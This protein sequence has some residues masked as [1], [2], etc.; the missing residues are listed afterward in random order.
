MKLSDLDAGTLDVS[1]V[2]LQTPSSKM[3]MFLQDKVKAKYHCRSDSV[4][5]IESKADYKRV[6]AV[7]GVYPP[8]AD[9]WYVSVNLDKFSD[10]ELIGLIKQ[11]TTCVFFCTCSKYRTFKSFKDATKGVVGICDFYINS[12]RRADFVYLY[13]IFTPKDNRLTKQLFDYVFKS[14]SGDIEAVFDLFLQLGQGTKIETRKD[15]AEICGLGG[16]SVESYIFDLLKDLSGSDKGLKTVI[17]NRTKAGSELCSSIGLRSMYNFMARSV[18]LLCELKMLMIS[19]VVYKTVRKLPD[20]FDEQ[21]LARYQKYIWRL[22]EIPLSK[23]LKLRQCI[24]EKPWRTELDFLGFIYTYYYG[25]SMDL[26]A[27]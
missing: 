18:G 15:I 26:I 14:Y 12:I 13:D 23:L 20:S 9:K 21:A 2:I 5:D 11:S 16:L 8:F 27:S 4:I 25:K 7:L 3:T 17:K 1:V 24:G 22:R 10:K 6:K 19:G